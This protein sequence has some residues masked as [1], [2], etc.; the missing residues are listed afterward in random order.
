MKFKSEKQRRKVMLEV[1]RKGY[2]RKPYMRKSY[3]KDVKPGPG[4]KMRRI[5]ATHVEKTKVSPTTFKIKDI[6]AP[7]RGRKIIPIKKGK[8]TKYGYSTSK[9][10]T[11]R[12]RALRK[13]DRAYGS[14][15]LF[16]MLQAQVIMRKRTQPK[17]RKIFEEDRDWVKKNLMSPSER[18][19]MT[20]APRKEW[21]C[22]TPKERA[23]AMPGG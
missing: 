11:V 8:L 14:V 7:G 22:M 21:M 10:D 13:A 6:G 5:P 15:A 16:R 18:R 17:A 12:H 2:T 9:S 20:R 1:R 19:S 4:V 23:K 3:M